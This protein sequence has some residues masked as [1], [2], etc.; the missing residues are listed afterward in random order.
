MRCSK[1]ITWCS[2][3]WFI[4]YYLLPMC[5]C[6]YHQNAEGP[7]IEVTNAANGWDSLMTF[8]SFL[9]TSCCDDQ[10]YVQAL[11]RKENHISAN[12]TRFSCLI[13]G[14]SVTDIVWVPFWNKMLAFE[15]KRIHLIGQIS[16]CTY[17]IQNKSWANSNQISYACSRD[18]SES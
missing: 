13:Y 16:T 17:Y 1:Q 12:L 11:I 8:H 15:S 10:E 2:N 3:G 18:K 7:I 9:I 4:S 14:Q 6:V 5:L